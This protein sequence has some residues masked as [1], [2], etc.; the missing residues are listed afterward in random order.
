VIH[1]A[2]ELADFIATAAEKYAF[3]PGQLVA[4]GYSNGANIAAA[5]MLLRPE[6]IPAAILFRAMP[7]LTNSTLPDL[8]GHRVLLTAGRSDS[9]IPPE[10]TRRLTS[11]LQEAGAEV[12]LEVQAAGHAL[13]HEDLLVAQRWLAHP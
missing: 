4:V 1:R 8:R 9:I 3:P 13:V 7:T 5:M 12:E 10:Q 11:L 2:N 6:S